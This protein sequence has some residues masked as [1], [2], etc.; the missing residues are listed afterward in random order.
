MRVREA[1]RQLRRNE[2]GELSLPLSP[3]LDLSS[4]PLGPALFRPLAL[5]CQPNWKFSK[6]GGLT[7]DVVAL[8]LLAAFLSSLCRYTSFSSL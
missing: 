8:S 7:L 3:F 5:N 6:A 1:T 4:E 2:Q